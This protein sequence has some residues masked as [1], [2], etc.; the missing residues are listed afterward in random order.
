MTQTDGLQFTT[1]IKVGL[2]V[3]EK[4]MLLLVDKTSK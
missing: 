4:G 3:I 1:H 2:H